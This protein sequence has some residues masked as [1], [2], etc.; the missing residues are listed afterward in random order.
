MT[1]KEIMNKSSLNQPI[2]PWLLAGDWLLIAL[3]VFIGQRDHDMAIIASLP[4]FF[5]TTLALTLPWT[6]VAWLMGALRSPR[7]AE[8]WPWLGR[9]AA[10]WLIASPLGL[11]LR[12]WSR[13]QGSIA[14]PFMLVTLGLGVLSM[15]AWRA[16]AYWWAKRKVAP[17]S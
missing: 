14:V 5:S 17:A 6:V 7:W 9:V 11:I 12:A 15:L 3:F 13:Q 8:L 10:A 16:L 2:C 4:S 1:N